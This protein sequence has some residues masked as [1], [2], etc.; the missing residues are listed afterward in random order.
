MPQELVSLNSDVNLIPAEEEFGRDLTPTSEAWFPPVFTARVE[1]RLS[2]LNRPFKPGDV[3][4]AFKA[5]EDGDLTAQMDLFEQM[6]EMDGSLAGFMNTRRLAPAG[7]K[8]SVIPRANDPAAIKAAD[9]CRE[10][11]DLLA[12]W[13]SAIVDLQDGVGKG[14][15]VMENDYVNGGD[16]VWLTALR[17]IDGK[18]YQF[19]RNMERLLIKV[20]QN[21]NG[22]FSGLASGSAGL[23]MD[24]VPPPP[25]KLTIHRTRMRPGHAS[26]AGVLRVITLAFLIRN[27]GLKD[28]ST[29]AEIFGMPLRLG[30]YPA[31]TPDRDKLALLEAVRM[32]GSDAAAIISDT[33][34]VEFKDSVFRGTQPYEALYNAMRTEMAIAILG[35][36]LTNTVGPTGARAQAQ[37]QQMVRQDLLEA[38]CE[39]LSETIERD[40]FQPLVG[41]NL[42]WDIASMAR[43]RFKLHYEPVPD[44]QSQIDVD[45]KLFLPPEM[46]G[47]G[48]PFTKTQLYSRYGVEP[49]PKDAKPDDMVI[50]PALMERLA[51]QNAPQ[52]PRDQK[53]ENHDTRTAE[54]RRIQQRQA[55]SGTNAGFKKA[56]KMIDEMSAEEKAALVNLLTSGE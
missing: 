38:D 25:Y 17:H 13:R 16:R 7:L 49:P 48:L 6:E 24:G 47:L 36:Q 20:N 26:R 55:F 23:M 46:G 40:I 51:A 3:A 28:W 8:W 22:S 44:L 32:L 15:S 12:T 34:E 41:W 52:A 37:V 33:T 30:K 2:V 27:F 18:R 31:G 10:N 14:L 53:G 21:D 29:Y 9:L 11:L 54:T 1:D 5:A 45:V 35:Q 50:D 42:G 56:L 4:S 39:Q 43:P 19:D